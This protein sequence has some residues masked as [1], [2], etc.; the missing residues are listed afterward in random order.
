MVKPESRRTSPGAYSLPTMVEMLGL[1]RPLPTTIT[2]R[3]MTKV[4]RSGAI[5]MKLPTA[6]SAPP[7][8]I[9]RW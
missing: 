1:N 7:S 2:A 6:I 9:E 8:M 4:V 5:S 3:P